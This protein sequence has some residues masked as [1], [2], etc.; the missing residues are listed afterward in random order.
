MSL[1]CDYCFSFIVVLCLLLGMKVNAT[2]VTQVLLGAITGLALVLKNVGFVMG[3]NGA[4]MGSAIV[5]IFPSLLF[6]KSTQRRLASGDLTNSATLRV[7]RI[8]NRFIILFGVMCAILG[9]GVTL[10]D[11]FKPEL[12]R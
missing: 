3:L 5:Y 11:A 1:L 8:F 2:R 9:G 10:A 7:E 4:T 12:F 6:L